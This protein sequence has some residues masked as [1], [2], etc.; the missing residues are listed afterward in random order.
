MSYATHGMRPS[1]QSRHYKRLAATCER[2]AARA[3]ESDAPWALGNVR[4]WQN[5][6]CDALK[7]RS[8]IIREYLLQREYRKGYLG[9]LHRA[10]RWEMPPCK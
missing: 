6:M 5:Q 10:K 9:R 4:I 3:G 7:A 1:K 2:K 8:R